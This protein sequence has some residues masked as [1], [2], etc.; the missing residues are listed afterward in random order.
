M[1]EGP[2]A[3]LAERRGHLLILTINRPDARNAVNADVHV[4]LGEGLE[5]A[6]ADPEIRAVIITG[7]GEAFCAGADLKAVARGERLTPRDRRQVAWGFAGVVAHPISKPVIAAVNGMALGGGAEIALACDL[8]V[9]SKTAIFGLPEVKRGIIAAGGG[10]FRLVQQIPPKLALEYLLTGDAFTAERG[11]QLGL[12][13]QVVEPDELS[14]AALQLA[15]KIAANAPLAVQASKR[16]AYGLAEGKAI[17]DAGWWASSNA[18]IR[19]VMRSEDA[20]EGPLAFVEK[21]RPNWKAR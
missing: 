21:R 11:H 2:E 7:A 14:A 1:S 15:E 4:G 16:V 12:I 17:N 6:E 9:A 8:I 3:V 20:L 5:L 13:N 19:A 10:A 18:E